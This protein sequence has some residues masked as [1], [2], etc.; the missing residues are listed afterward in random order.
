MRCQPPA[1]V[2]H[3]QKCLAGAAIPAGSIDHRDRACLL[4]AP[5]RTPVGM[6]LHVGGAGGAAG[7]GGLQRDHP[8]AAAHCLRGGVGDGRPSG[9][10][11]EGGGPA[12]GERVTGASALTSAAHS[13]NM[14]MCAPTSMTVSP[15][16]SS[17]P[18]CRYCRSTKCS[19]YMKST[20]SRLHG[21]LQEGSAPT[22]AVR[23][24]SD[25]GR[26]RDLPRKGRGPRLPHHTYRAAV[27][28]IIPA[29]PT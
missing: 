5:R 8:A 6:L 23:M 21:A 29:W 1:P 4:P 20:S 12:G 15:G 11:T 17:T 27:E 28:N 26:H 3:S 9:R 22:D 19:R 2:I 10:R 25:L 16:L 24:R 13:V 18:C 14:P 7:R